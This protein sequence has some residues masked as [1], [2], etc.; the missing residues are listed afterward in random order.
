MTSEQDLLGGCNM[1]RLEGGWW[2]IGLGVI[3]VAV[4]VRE[5]GQGWQQRRVL[6]RYRRQYWTTS[7]WSWWHWGLR[8]ECPGGEMSL[9]Y[10][11][12]GED[13]CLVLSFPG[14]SREVVFSS[15]D[16]EDATRKPRRKW[17]GRMAAYVS[18]D[19][20]ARRL[21]YGSEGPVNETLKRVWIPMLRTASVQAFWFA[22][23]REGCRGRVWLRMAGEQDWELVRRCL[24]QVF[25]QAWLESHEEM[26]LKGSVERESRCGLCR[27][28]VEEKGVRCRRCGL[29]H[30]RECWEYLSKCGRCG[31]HEEAG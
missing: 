10:W 22:M 3:G 5:L 21:W 28:E 14:V 15:H 11:R 7:A 24:E 26:V 6:L 25:E 20:G 18:S 13:V 23:G 17:G 1:G 29:L 27:Q 2:W 31:S 30:H 9:R 8:Q 16:G 4:V 19:L 12:D